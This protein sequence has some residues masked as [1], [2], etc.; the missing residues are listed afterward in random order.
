MKYSQEALR[1]MAEQINLYEYA[2]NTVEFT[3]HCGTIHY[4]ECVF[5]EEKTPSL[6][7]YETTN[8]YYCF[9]CGEHGNIYT[10][11]Q[12]TENKSFSEAVEKV[13][14]I[15]GCEVEE[16]IESESVNF[17]KELNRVQRPIKEQEVER[18]ILDMQLDYY[19]KYSDV[20]PQEWLAEGITEESMK[21]YDIRIDDN[22]NRIVYPVLDAEFNLIGIKG[23][24]RFENFKA[25]KLPKYINYKKIGA[26]DFFTGMKLAE[27]YIKESGRII[28]VEGIKTVMKLDGW[29]YHNVVSAETSDITEQQLI[30]L[31]RMGIKTAVIAFDEDVPLS[32][33]NKL[34]KD[35]RSYMNV[36]VVI[37]KK[38]LLSEKDSPTD[39]GREVWEK[40]YSER[41]RLK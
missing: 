41:I 4:C 17:L 32:K 7:F 5:H 12:K 2:E 33:I 6:A 10:W 27:P 8:Q 26:L 20:T 16:Y 28:I 3:K 18:Q 35:M 1:S 22:A 31:I 15:T 30:I 37:N 9:G 40:L 14:A 21:K 23:R 25:L 29:G 11:I 19:D 36:E 24:T 34:T 39:K 13:A 38:N